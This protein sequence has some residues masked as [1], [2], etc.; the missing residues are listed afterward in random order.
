MSLIERSASLRACLSGPKVALTISSTRDSN[1][2]R[3]TL[4]FMCLGPEPS[5][6]MYG[7][8]TSVCCAE[9]SSHFAFSAAS[10]KRCIANG[11]CV[12]SMP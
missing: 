11:S 9:E 6:V 7:K 1:L 2:A 3:V 8:L 12:K 5:A 4:M 10:F